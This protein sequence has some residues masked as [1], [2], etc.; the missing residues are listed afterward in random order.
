MIQLQFGPVSLNV[1]VCIGFNYIVF[2][3]TEYSIHNRIDSFVY[4]IYVTEI[5]FYLH[6]LYT[7]LFV[8]QRR[9]DTNTLMFHHVLCIFLMLISYSNK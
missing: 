8:D 4:G 7:T 1:F 5:G 2:S 9:K 3:F 6:S